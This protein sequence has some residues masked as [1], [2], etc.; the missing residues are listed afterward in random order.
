MREE[1]EMRG[2]VNV[3]SPK[4]WSLHDLD[5]SVS[6]DR[7]ILLDI[8]FQL[9]FFFLSL[10][11]LS[12]EPIDFKLIYKMTKRSFVFKFVV[13]MTVN[14]SSFGTWQNEDIIF[15]QFQFYFTFIKSMILFPNK[16]FKKKHH[17]VCCCFKQSC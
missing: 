11:S 15:N 5:I 6:L 8:F 1:K 9:L 17:F 4:V 3:K 14:E 16:F 10:V 13:M 12:N 7:E 2:D